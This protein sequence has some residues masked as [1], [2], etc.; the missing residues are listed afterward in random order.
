[1]LVVWG[2]DLLA[3]LLTESTDGVEYTWHTWLL[4]RGV[5]KVDLGE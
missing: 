5:M 2:H 1:M 4:E 3:D